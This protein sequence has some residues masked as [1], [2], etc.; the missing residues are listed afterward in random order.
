MSTPTD[1]PRLPP[2]S[3]PYADDLAEEL[4]KWMPPGSAEPLALFRTLAH[5][6]ALMSRMRPLGSGLL[7]HGA[8]E[9]R[10]REIV[11]HRICARTGAEYEWGVHAVI[12]ARRHGVTE[13]Q[14]AA[15]VHGDA[16]DPAWSERDALL[17]RI[18]DQ[19]CDHAAVDTPTYTAAA[20][21]WTPPQLLEL[22]ILAG[23]YR[24][25]AGIL[26]T[27]QTPLEPWAARFPAG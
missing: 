8:V 15:T 17:I 21:H 1:A 26:R 19:L 13:A 20:A 11:I 23:W 27:A 10:D 18:A 5:H 4:R 22:V 6:P 9:P 7:N 25:I 3:P 12:F 16:S 14:L 24:L 2:L